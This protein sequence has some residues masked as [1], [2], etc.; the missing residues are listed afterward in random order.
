MY[1]RKK[2]F[3]YNIFRIYLWIT[4][5][6]RKFKK[7]KDKKLVKS[8]K[9]ISRNFILTKFHFLQFQKWP[10][11][12]FWTGKKFETAKNAISRKNFFDLFDFTSFFAWTFLYFL[13]Y[14]ANFFLICCCSDGL[15]CFQTKIY[16]IWTNIFIRVGPKTL[17]EREIDAHLRID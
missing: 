8:N 17:L 4:Q 13:A 7:V 11:I 6:A 10:K 9:S 12:N 5:W 14:C 15:P 3:I 16:L 1:Q 2:N